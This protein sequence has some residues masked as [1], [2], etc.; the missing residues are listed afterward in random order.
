[1]TLQPAA[2]PVLET[3]RL[4]LRGLV[5]G[6]LDGFC[7]I[8]SDPDHARFIGGVKSREACLEKLLALAGHWQLFGWGRFAVEE[9]TSGEFLGHCGPTYVGNLDQPEVNYSFTP[10]AAGRGFA[11]EAVERILA[12]VYHDLGWVEAV[13][14]IDRDNIRSQRLATR[15][16]AYRDSHTH[17]KG[18]S[19]IEP[20]VYPSAAAYLNSAQGRQ[21]A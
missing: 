17:A 6:D 20:W 18:R 12:H 3:Q 7:R 19:N 2:L 16:G 1:M 10:Q 4:R 14:M 5:A 11:T 13:S 8:Y 21:T 9:K 15:L